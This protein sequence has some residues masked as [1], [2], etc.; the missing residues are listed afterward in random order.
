MKK[1][2]IIGNKPY[3]N[4]IMDDVINSFERNIRCNLGL[5]NN[6]NGNKYDRLGL[7]SHLYYYLIKKNVSQK[8]FISIYKDDYNIEFINEFFV[9][10]DPKN[11]KKVFHA[12]GNKPFKLMFN[13]YLKLIGSPIILNK[14]GR[15]GINLIMTSLLKNKKPYITNFT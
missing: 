6:N 14:M 1:I 3:R 11:F 13:I 5:P 15:T 8:E 4:F 10:F 7:C 2:L 12:K 9:R